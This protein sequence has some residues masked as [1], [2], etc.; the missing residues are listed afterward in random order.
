MFEIDTFV[1]SE[2]FLDSHLFALINLVPARMDAWAAFVRWSQG[3]LP[4]HFCCIMRY[5]QSFVSVYEC[6]IINGG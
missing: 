2:C 6:P 1:Q 5:L 3:G 4:L